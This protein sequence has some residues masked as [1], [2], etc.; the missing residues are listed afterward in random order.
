MILF[1]IIEALM[2]SCSAR[3]SYFAQNFQMV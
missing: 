1:L 3:L 2:N